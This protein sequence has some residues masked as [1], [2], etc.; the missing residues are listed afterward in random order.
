MLIIQ[1]ISLFLALVILKSLFPIKSKVLSIGL[2]VVLTIVFV[3]QLSSVIVTG[4]I[5]NYR[6]YENFNIR[7]VLSV[8]GFFGK[9]GILISLSLII[10]ALLM[11]YSSKFLRMRFRNNLYVY[12]T[13]V[14]ALI[15]LSLNGGIIHNAYA[16]MRLKFTG[17][18]TF[19]DALSS[20]QI[21]DKEYIRRNSIK[22][23]KGKNIIVLSLESLEKGYLN[24][25]L[26][27]LTPNL[28]KLAEQYT[29]YDMKQSPAGGWTSA[30]MYIAMTGVPAYFG[31]HGNSVFQS[32]HEN[33]LTSLT[34][35]LKKAN[36]DL[37]Y[38]IGRKEFSGI[39][40]MLKM[41]GFT[42][43][44]EKDFQV[45]YDEVAWG[46]QD[47][48]LFT[49]FKKEIL[50]KKGSDTPFALFL[51]TISTHFPN[52]VS[53]K[54]MDS[55][56]PPQKSRLELMV[57]ATDYLIGDLMDFLKKEEFLDNTVVYIY[58]DHL[59]M[60]N[61]SRVL[62]DFEERQLYLLTN[63]DK[64]KL[65]QDP[66]RPI[67][68]IDLPKIILE[69]AEI[70]HNAKFLTDFILEEDKDSFLRENNQELLS[71]ND[72]ALKTSN[73]KEGIFISYQEE[74]DSLV[75]RNK[76]GVRLFTE[77]IP[78]E[79]DC[80]R[81][82]FDENLR[83]ME[84]LL[85]DGSKTLPRPETFAYLDVFMA[86]NRLHSSLKGKHHFG[87]TKEAKRRL[88]FSQSD[89]E[90]LSTI[91]LAQEKRKIIKL[92]SSSWHAKKPSSFIVKGKKQNI[93]RGL[94]V[95]SFNTL[96]EYEFRTFDTYGSPD[97]AKALVEL[98]KK[99]DEDN[100]LYVILAHDSAA[101]SLKPLI[102]GIKEMG[103]IK[104]SMLQDRQA[105]IAHNLNGGITEIMND[106]I[107]ETE[108]AFPKDLDQ[109]IV[110][111]SKPKLEFEPSIDRFIAHAGGM[112]DGIRYTNSLEALDYSYSLGFKVFELDVI[113]TSDGAFVAA[114][115]WNHWAKITGYTGELPV[116]REEFLKHKLYKKYTSMD[117]AL[118]NQW[119]QEHP[120]ATLVTDKVNEPLNFSRE[121][122]DKERLQ[123]E[124]FSLPAVEEALQNGVTPFITDIPISQI[125]GDIIAYLKKHKIG[126][127]TMSRR[128][129]VRKA[130]LL[131]RYKENN[132]KVYVY[133]VS[134]D[135][136]K[137]EHHVLNNEIGLVYGMY[138]DQWIPEF[139]NGILSD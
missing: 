21:E 34:D 54:R 55:L 119:F 130:D 88:I 25:K 87:I 71:L 80:R 93:T 137:D 70:K 38:F 10:F 6:F 35:V 32:S 127:V 7:D 13:L 129:V 46:I 135:A 115:D 103:F 75:I 39:D 100:A 28:S 117:M 138:A 1:L 2:L 95:I 97:E 96:S 81:I 52:G 111:F 8:V 134:F 18:A 15:I 101:K 82:I 43:K 61:K 53:D 62:E 17:N 45:R 30:S 58:P 126:Y 86:N 113:Q 60:G 99:F 44:S 94:T 22:A 47:K 56:L 3:V 69:G 91:D 31:V 65:S 112:I 118:I 90:L 98:L 107:I 84:S 122:V 19:N 24:E 16:T 128:N 33:K 121:F 41:F 114:H 102:S 14:L 66:N 51:S 67:H 48:D 26:K 77:R 40:D 4:E 64:S 12:L 79:G 11:Y 36:Y 74:N 50:R 49:E 83:P 125:Q 76:E 116:S 110:Y 68:Q 105:Y 37:Q 20:L 92:N 63:A 108:L 72:A 57:S 132:I 120:D 131:K 23:S 29:L 133:H 124:L 27:H 123:M 42:V 73:C 139:K 85:L 104:L 106:S 5:A 59:L 9:E 78:D 136:G 109:N 89:I